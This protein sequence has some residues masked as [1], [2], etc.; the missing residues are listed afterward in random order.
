MNELEAS[1]VVRA[2]A[3]L[4]A[5]VSSDPRSNEGYSAVKANISAA[6]DSL[7]EALQNF[8]GAGR[9]PNRSKGWMEDLRRVAD[10]LAGR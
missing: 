10:D 8:E 6:L 3:E 5:G 9:Q 4:L 1:L 7:A 2:G